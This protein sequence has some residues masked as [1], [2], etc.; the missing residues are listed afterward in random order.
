MPTYDTT[1]KKCNVKLGTVTLP[2]APEDTEDL[3]RL[4]KIGACKAC[5]PDFIARRSGKPGDNLLEQARLRLRAANQLR[6]KLEQTQEE[7]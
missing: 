3:E 6:K 5:A 2:S 7:I 1:C 4:L